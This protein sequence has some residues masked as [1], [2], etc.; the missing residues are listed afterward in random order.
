VV[1]LL[2]LTEQAQQ[3]MCEFM[4]GEKTEYDRRIKE[5]LRNGKHP[6]FKFDNGNAYEGEWLNGKMHGHGIYIWASG[7]SY[8]GRR[9]R[10][11][12]FCMRAE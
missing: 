10:W 11:I 7:N 8:E 12:L 4:T 3:G 1:A 9:K 5:T 6:L 2:Q